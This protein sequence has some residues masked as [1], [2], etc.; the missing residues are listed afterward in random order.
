M[1]KFRQIFEGNNSAYGQLVLTGETT[2]KGKA[3]GKA[4]IKREPIPEQLWQDHLDGKDPALGVIPINENNSC[5]W[6]CIDV[7][8]YN[9]DHKKLAASIKSHK[10][11]LVMFR[12]KSGGAHL[13]LFTTDFIMASLM[14]AKLKM[15]SEALGFGGSEIFPKQIQLN[16]KGTGNFLNLP[17]NNP[18]YPTRYAFDDEG[19]SLELEEF[20]NYYKEK[21]VSNLNMVVIEKNIDDQ[22]KEDFK[23]APP[24]LTTIATQGFGEGSRNES[25]FQLG[26]YLRQRFPDQLEQKLDQ[27]NTKYFNPPLPSREVLTIFKQVEDKKYFYRCEEPMFKTVCEKIKCQSQKFGIGNSATN[28]ISGLKKWVSDNPV[29]E[30]TH[31]GK[32]IILTVDQLSS[33]AEYR[34]QCI[35][36]ANESPRPVAPAI[37]ADMVQTLLSNMQEDDFI[38]LPGEVTAKGQFLNQL[39]IFIENNRGAKDRQDVL[40]GMVFELK[41]YFF[42]KPQAFRDFLKTKRFTKASD[43]EQYK[44]FEEFKGTTAKLKVN[45]NVEHC[46]KIPTTILESEYRLSKKDF[47][48]EEAY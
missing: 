10:F 16:Q 32:V 37:W 28:E 8:E 17:Y 18:K 33:H 34:K 7:D 23:Q 40:Q 3:V 26:I 46:W 6:G 47:S 11:P 19:N 12:S 31:N 9:L 44:M 14:Q 48:E 25:M 27:Y 39:Q 22:L 35:A 38:Q 36:Q 13:F 45:N 20:I 1:Q 15:M 30:L 24:C 41:D 5:R 4:F 21:V 42:F 2:D 29:Y 43:S